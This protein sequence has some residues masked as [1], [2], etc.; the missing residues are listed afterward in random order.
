MCDQETS[1]SVDKCDQDIF[2]PRNLA[3]TRTP[4]RSQLKTKTKIIAVG[5]AEYAAFQGSCQIAAALIVSAEMLNGF[6]DTTFIGLIALDAIYNF[7]VFATRTFK[8]IVSAT[9]NPETVI[10]PLVILAKVIE[11]V[12][13]AVILVDPPAVLRPTR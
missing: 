9:T 7:I 13:R 3:A 4:V 10:F 11:F 1:F 2:P 8:V 5:F 6:P 12:K